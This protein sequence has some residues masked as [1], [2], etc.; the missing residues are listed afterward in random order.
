MKR[1]GLAV[2]VVAALVFGSESILALLRQRNVNVSIEVKDHQPDAK[3]NPGSIMTIVP[4]SALLARVVWDYKIGPRFPDTIVHVDVMDQGT[5]KVVAS[6]E[7]KIDCG[8]ESLNCGGT[9]PVALDYGVQNNQGTRAAWPAGD[10]R[11]Q[12][13]RTFVG[14]KPVSLINMPLRVAATQ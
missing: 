4:D 2:I 5:G 8:M 7:Y 12:V 6:N 1:L 10:Y 14:F 9:V 11:V 3:P 13:T